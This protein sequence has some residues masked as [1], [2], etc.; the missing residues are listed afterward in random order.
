[1]H[2][3]DSA[4]GRWQARLEDG[5]ARCKSDHGRPTGT[6]FYTLDRESGKLLVAKPFIDGF[7]LAKEVGLG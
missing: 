2:D 5:R 7:E 3:W 4:H 1:V 6:A